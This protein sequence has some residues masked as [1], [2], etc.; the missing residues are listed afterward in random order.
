MKKSAFVLPLDLLR[1]NVTFFHQ[2]NKSSCKYFCV[3]I[4]KLRVNVT[5]TLKNSE[6][7]GLSYWKSEKLPLSDCRAHRS[8]LTLPAVLDVHSVYSG[9]LRTELKL[10]S[11]E[12][13]Q[14]VE[15]GLKILQGNGKMMLSTKPV[16]CCVMPVLTEMRRFTDKYLF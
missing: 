15:C 12:V 8:R 7:T 16:L 3:T 11:C 6:L 1:K 2:H 13:F 14:A 5:A 9:Q 10:D 4:R